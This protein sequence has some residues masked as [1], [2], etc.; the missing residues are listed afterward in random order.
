MAKPKILLTRPLAASQQWA[1]LLS[2]RG[3]DCQIEPLL[4]IEPTCLP[5]PGAHDLDT[6]DLDGLLLTSAHAISF[7]P[8]DLELLPCYVVGA[9]TA[10]ALENTGFHAVLV[11]SGNG[12]DLAQA[13]T[14][15]PQPPRHLLHACGSDV[16]TSLYAILN[17]AGITVTPWPLY[18]AVAASD[19]SDQLCYDLRQGT[20]TVIPIFSPRS[21]QILTDLIMRKNLTA[22]CARITVVALSAAVAETLSTISWQRI[23]I[24]A[25]PS[26]DAVLALVEK[27]CDRTI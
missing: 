20:I 8:K 24:A 1:Q 26:A 12:A 15:Q 13:I 23:D 22:A 6:S 11:G 27:A 25:V 2:A 10:E 14:T 3:L 18:N 17:Q 16:A 19:L 4:T 7:L 21:A 9:A 5:R